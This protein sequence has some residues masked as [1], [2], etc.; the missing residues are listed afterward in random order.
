MSTR[1]PITTARAGSLHGYDVIDPTRVNPELGGEEALRKLV[2]A[3]RAAGLGLIV[4]IVPN[5]MAAGAENAWWF[6]VLRHGPQSRYAPYFDI[7]WN[8]EDEGLRGKVL[9]P[10]LGK[11]LREAIEAGELRIE[12][13]ELRYF[14]HRFPLRRGRGYIR[15]SRRTARAPALS[16]CVVAHR[17]RC[18]QLAALLRHQRIGRA[19]HGASARV[20]G[21]ACADLPALRRRPDRWRAGRSC[22]W[23]L[24]SGRLL[25]QAA[26]ASRSADGAAAR[27]GAARAAVH[28]GREN[29]AA[30][31]DAC[32]RTG[33]ATAP[34]ATTS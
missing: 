12:G 14:E 21:Y 33:R 22:R 17:Q 32:P 5:H 19:A 31:R 7:D 8:A 23:P 2:A 24:R 29:F 15:S 9:L 1:R 4:D 16:A 28:R 20:R 25:P 34:A 27:I 30:R 18:D 13:D 6:D 11:P 10:V 26:P 3:L